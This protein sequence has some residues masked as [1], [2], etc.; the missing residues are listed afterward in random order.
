[1]LSFAFV[2][3]LVSVVFEA[4]IASRSR[5]LR[6]LAGRRLSVNLGVSLGL[7]VVLGVLFGA[8]GLIALTAGLMSTVMAIPVYRFLH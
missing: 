2:L 8:V 3:V 4:M 1:M 7:S 5:A 6:R